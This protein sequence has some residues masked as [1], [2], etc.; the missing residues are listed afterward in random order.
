MRRRIGARWGKGFLEGFLLFM[1]LVD[2]GDL[3]G[4]GNEAMLSKE[5]S[6]I[7]SLQQP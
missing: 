1:L 6:W 4:T 3:M 7:G 5:D 2:F